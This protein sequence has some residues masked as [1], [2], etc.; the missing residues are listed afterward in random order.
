M[1]L[2]FR[3]C[4][5]CDSFKV[6]RQKLTYGRKM[7]ECRKQFTCLLANKMIP[8]KITKYTCLIEIYKQF[9]ISLKITNKSQEK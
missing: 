8:A 4:F 7:I 5:S 6:K 3:V 9:R 1:N 2:L